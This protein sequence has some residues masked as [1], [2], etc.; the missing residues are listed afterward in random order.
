MASHNIN[1]GLPTMFG[2]LSLR[3][4]SLISVRFKFCIADALIGIT[5]VIIIVDKA[6]AIIL[7]IV[8]FFTKMH[9][10]F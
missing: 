5:C 8:F 4:D 3:L 2:T 10:L 1:C 9:P 7:F 6:D